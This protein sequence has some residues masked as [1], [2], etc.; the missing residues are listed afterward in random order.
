M[1][2]RSS[3]ND[4]GSETKTLC[5]CPDYEICSTGKVRHDWMTLF[6]V[7]YDPYHMFKIDKVFYINQNLD[8]YGNLE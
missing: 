1:I 7:W 4:I 5:G 8:Y 6:Q 3:L 2:R